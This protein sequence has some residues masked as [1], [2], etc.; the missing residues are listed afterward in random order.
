[1]MRV[2]SSHTGSRSYRLTHTTVALALILSVLLLSAPTTGFADS[3]TTSSKEEKLQQLKKQINE[4]RTTLT[5]KSN[6][7][8]QLQQQLRKNETAIGKVSLTLKRLAK[9]LKQ[10]QRELGSLNREEKTKAN[11]L[12]QQQQLLAQQIRASYAMGNQGYAKLFLNQNDPAAIGRTLVYYDYLNQSR[13]RNINTID[14]R[15]V[16]LSRIK[17]DIERKQTQI[18]KAQQKQRQQKSALEEKRSSRKKILADIEKDIKNQSQRLVQLEEAR[19]D[20]ETLLSSLRDTL[21]DIPPD[22]GDV[23]QFSQLKG[24][25]LHPTRGKIRNR[26]GKRSRNGSL[27]QGLTISAKT[28]ADVKAVHHGRIAFSDWLRGFGLL[29]IIDHGDGYMSLYGHNESL[30]RDVGE[31]VETGD[32]IATVG[33]SGGQSSAGL[34]FEIRQNGKPINPK[35]WLARR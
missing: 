12:Q 24:K 9:Q 29:V 33:E 6:T 11:E 26:F 13:T 4:T 35:P 21:A 19:R 2:A 25:L 23:A 30:Y 20:L 32:V 3:N 28:G 17:T 16:A 18:K 34:Y 31:W 27:W 8:N 15:I 10:Q 14:Q 1:M 7:R 5:K 22:A